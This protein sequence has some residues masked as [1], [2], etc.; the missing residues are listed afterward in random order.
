MPTVHRLA[1]A[2]AEPAVGRECDAP[3]TRC[4]LELAHTIVAMVGLEVKRVR[5]KTCGS[6]HNYRSSREVAATKP[7]AERTPV[8]PESVTEHLQAAADRG[9]GKAKPGNA[10]QRRADAVT[11]TRARM[12]RIAWTKAM[13]DRDRSRAVRYAASVTI[14]PGQLVDHKNFGYGVVES[15]QDGKARLLF[16]DGWRVLVISRI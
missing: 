2:D 9:P 8:P 16:E 11:A 7:R 1:R 10:A 15:V 6:E 4:K 5:C 14:A 3:C 12:A 13:G